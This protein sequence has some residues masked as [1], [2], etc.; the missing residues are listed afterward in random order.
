MNK[1]SNI[2]YI[3]K[4]NATETLS[5]TNI[6]MAMGCTIASSE[7]VEEAMD[8]LKNNKPCCIIVD[9]HLH[10]I[11]GFDMVKMVRCDEDLSSIPI[12]VLTALDFSV[13][14]G[15]YDH[16]KHYD[17]DTLKKPIDPHKLRKKI[18]DYIH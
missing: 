7:R 1:I 13:M 6:L 18:A 12:I 3:V 11:S 5:L 2:I 9:A 15:K 14:T 16:I 10:S 17:F 4:E 8:Q